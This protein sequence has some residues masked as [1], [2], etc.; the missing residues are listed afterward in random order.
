VIT[1]WTKVDLMMYLIYFRLIL[2]VLL[3]WCSNELQRI[4]T[5]FKFLK[6]MTM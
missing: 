3:I 4:L 6:L 2:L 5:N 1:S